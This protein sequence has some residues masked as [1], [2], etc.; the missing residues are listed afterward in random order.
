MDADYADNQK[1]IVNILAQVEILLHSLEWSPG[2]IGLN[3]NS[4]KMSF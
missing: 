3:M 2:T 1:L 4:D